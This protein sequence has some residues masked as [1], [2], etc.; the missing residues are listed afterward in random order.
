[1][2]LAG[3]CAL[4]AV[5]RPVAPD[6]VPDPTIDPRA[7]ERA[8]RADE[9][10]AR[11]A[12]RERLDVDVRALGDAVRAYGRADEAGDEAALVA[13]RRRVVEAARQA[14]RFGA[15]AV[16][17][18][19]AYELGSFLRELRRWEATGEVTDE[20]RELGGGFLHT[21][22]R[23]RWV[24]PG[25]RVRMER[26]ALAASFKKRWNDLT[27]LQ[28]TALD[29]DLDE[30]RALYRFLLHNPAADRFLA[31][32][33]HDGGS[34]GRPGSAPIPPR[35]TAG[36]GAASSAADQ[37]RLR[38]VD[39]LSALDPSY[40]RDL[41]R[42]VLQFRLGRYPLAVEAFRRHLEMHP[43]GPHTL[44]AQNYLRAALGRAND[45]P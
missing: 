25:R 5:P 9:A 39:E 38:K 7:L 12:E 28:G 42:G 19:R 18:L 16:V 44:R 3:T 41:A 33:V 15:E 40:P 34:P 24:G 36:S 31:P 35:G 2:F 10:L 45:E 8:A 14:T 1:V 22:E 17:R 26:A 13:A 21:L 37:F 30:L 32:S 43:E 11:A 27:Q 23:N 29:P 4:L 6:E 20:L